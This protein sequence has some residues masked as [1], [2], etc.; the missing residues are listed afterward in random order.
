MDLYMLS[1]FLEKIRVDLARIVE[2]FV[3][4]LQSSSNDMRVPYAQQIIA[5]RR[6][7]WLKP[8]FLKKIEDLQKKVDKFK[9]KDV[10]AIQKPILLQCASNAERL[11]WR[12]WSTLMDLLDKHPDLVD[13][14]GINLRSK[15]R[16]EV[17]EDICYGVSSTLFC[18]CNETIW[19]NIASRFTHDICYMI[20]RNLWNNS[21][22]KN[23]TTI[24]EELVLLAVKAS[25][26]IRNPTDIDA[27]SF[28]TGIWKRYALNNRGAIAK[29]PRGT[30]CLMIL[31]NDCKG[32][33]KRLPAPFI[34][35]NDSKMDQKNIL[36]TIHKPWYLARQI[37]FVADT[38]AQKYLVGDKTYSIEILRRKLD[39]TSEATSMFLKRNIELDLESSLFYGKEFASIYSAGNKLNPLV[40][41]SIRK[42]ASNDATKKKPKRS[43]S[44]PVRKLLFWDVLV[45]RLQES[46][47]NIER[48]N[49]P[50]DWY[51]LPP[52][53]QRGKGFKP[54]IDFFDSAPLVINCLKTDIRYCHQPVIKSIMEEYGKCQAE[55][56]KMKSLK[57]TELKTLSNK[58]IVEK[59]RGKANTS[60]QNSEKADDIIQKNGIATVKVV[61]SSEQ[62]GLLLY[63]SDGQV[64]VKGIKN[65]DFEKQISSGD[66]M[67]AVGDFSIRNKSLADVCEL[68][69]RLGRPLTITFERKVQAHQN[70]CQTPPHSLP[71]GVAQVSHSTCDFQKKI[72]DKSCENKE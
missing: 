46:G 72:Y 43:F 11:D 19:S 50:N 4:K 8:F 30:K 35:R 68:V 13:E 69:R 53:V 32:P 40:E 33:E 66:V 70:P 31:A 61:F 26:G 2:T 71:Q 52:G 15:F 56:E 21:K 48:G 65:L 58:E 34:L 44:A 41:R 3:R 5:L 62:L 59:L 36:K 57:S 17:T 49:R 51:L 42:R 9:K 67:I 18:P 10:T 16:E 24:S 63:T 6:L 64:I 25:E 7:N 45:R 47:W 54:R 55:F 39:V 28:D 38:F 20:A 23:E 27:L 1:E 60:T 22:V 12:L 14:R 29:E 37:L